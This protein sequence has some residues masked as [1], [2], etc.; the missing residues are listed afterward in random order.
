MR[1]LSAS[2]PGAPRSDAAPYV[3]RD[4]TERLVRAAMLAR[5]KELT[6]LL[7]KAPPKVR[8]KLTRDFESEGERLPSLSRGA[9]LA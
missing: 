3:R 8:A 7:A 1:E 9:R 2:R 6:V 4:D 5:V